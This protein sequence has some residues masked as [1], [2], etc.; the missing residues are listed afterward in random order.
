MYTALPGV[1]AA[2][3]GSL[4]SRR[5][6]SLACSSPLMQPMAS[7]P[8]MPFTATSSSPGCRGRSPASVRSRFALPAGDAGT[9]PSSTRRCALKA[10]RAHVRPQTCCWLSRRSSTWKVR[11]SSSWTCAMTFSFMR[12]KSTHRDMISSAVLLGAPGPPFSPL[13][14]SAEA[15]A[16]A[17]LKAPARSICC[18]FSGKR[19]AC[20]RSSSSM[21]RAMGGVTPAAKRLCVTT[22]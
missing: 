14:A 10:A 4:A 11:D 12:T 5:N 1:W 18:S 17:S 13:A 20:F 16:S 9:T 22:S 21:L 2:T 19:S 7:Q 15:A 6:V 8:R 3:L